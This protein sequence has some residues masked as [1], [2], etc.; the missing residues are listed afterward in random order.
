MPLVLALARA[1]GPSPSGSHSEVWGNLSD[2]DCSVNQR[3]LP[4]V[5]SDISDLSNH[6]MMATSLA[7]ASHSL[8]VL[9]VVAVNHRGDSNDGDDDGGG[10]DH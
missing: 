2:S 1:R 8:V 10:D 5:H 4:P 7:H 6:V 9:M 3:T